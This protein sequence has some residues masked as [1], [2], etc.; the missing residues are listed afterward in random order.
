LTVNAQ[1]VYYLPEICEWINQQD[2]TYHF[3]NMLHEPFELNIGRMTDEAK[4]LV[5]EK[6]NTAEFAP[7]H[8]RQV[9]HIIRFIENGK[10]TDGTAFCARASRQDQYRNEDFSTLYP[11]VATAMGY[12]K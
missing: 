5:I 3:F 4:N 12:R 1:N 10:S 9:D 6:L 2:F 7:A 11:E 8:R